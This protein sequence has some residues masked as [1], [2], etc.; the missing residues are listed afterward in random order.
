MNKILLF[1]L[2]EEAKGTVILPC[3]NPTPLEV[4]VLSHHLSPVPTHEAAVSAVSSLYWRL[5]V[6]FPSYRLGN[7]ILFSP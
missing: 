1:I 4:A 3:I 6:G 2:L 7:M 5:G